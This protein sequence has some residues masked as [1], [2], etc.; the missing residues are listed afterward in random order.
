VAGAV[1]CI[2]PKNGRVIATMPVSSNARYLAASEGG[3]WVLDTFAATV[4]FIDGSTNQPHSP[5][6]VGTSPNGIAVG[7]GAVWV[8]DADGSLYRLD[9]VTNEVSATSVGT[10]L[11][12]VAVD[13]A[14]NIVWATTGDAS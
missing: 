2:E 14:D 6:G 7:L 12:A 13:E 10:P 11:T 5:V 9:A 1:R 3:V 8:A 4:T